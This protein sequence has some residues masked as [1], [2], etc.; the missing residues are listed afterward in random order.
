M[1]TLFRAC[2]KNS[3]RVPRNFLEKGFYER[4]IKDKVQDR[5]LHGLSIPSIHLHRLNDW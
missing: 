1:S 4:D 3:C 5:D 2:L